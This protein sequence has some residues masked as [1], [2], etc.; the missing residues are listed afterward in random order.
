MLA[1]SQE[2]ASA[3]GVNLQLPRPFD[4][5]VQQGE[6]DTSLSCTACSGAQTQL[7]VIDHVID[8]AGAQ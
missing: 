5:Y 2:V 1:A 6:S 8:H 3:V 7:D 4:D